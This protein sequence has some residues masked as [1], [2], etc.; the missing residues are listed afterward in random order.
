ML[1]G[2]VI[3]TRGH[4]APPSLTLNPTSGPNSV[5]GSESQPF[6]ATYT[7]VS[8]C[9]G[10]SVSYWWDAVG[11]AGMQIFGPVGLSTSS[12]PPCQVTN[13][14]NPPRGASCNV[15]HAVI[16]SEVDA[17]GAPAGQASFNYFLQCYGG[18]VTLRPTQGTP[19]Q[20]V[21]GTYNYI[22][23]YNGKPGSCPQYTNQVN[24]TWNGAAWFSST[25]DQSC[26]IA[27]NNAPPPTYNCGSN[28]Q[29]VGVFTPDNT[30]SSPASYTVNCPTPTPTSS[31]TSSSSTIT[32]S[33]ATSSSSSS[34]T[35]SSPT[36][37]TTSHHTTG[38]TSSVGGSPLAVPNLSTPGS[39][40]GASSPTLSPTPTAGGTTPS[41]TPIPG[42]GPA[43]PTTPP[44]GKDNGPTRSTF[45]RS[46]IDPRTINTDP[47]RI[48]VDLLIA[49]GLILVIVFPCELF[50]GTLEENY[51][52]VRGWFT[53]AFGA[54]RKARAH[55][56]PTPGWLIFPFFAVVM[57]GLY[58]LLD[59]NFGFD[60]TSLLLF[61][62]LLAG[63]IIVTIGFDLP[64]MLHVRFLRGER[65]E[66]TPYVGTLIVAGVCVLVSRLA[67][68][69]PGYLY[70]LVA[71]FSF[72]GRLNR[73]DEGRALAISAASVF[74]VSI[75]AYL[76]WVPVKDAAEQ[77]NPAVLALI[78]DAALATVFVAGLET[79]MFGLIPVRFLDG[80]KVIA[81]DK[82]GW[83]L[84]MGLGAFG[85]VHVVLDPKAGLVGWRDDTSALTVLA[86]FVGFG[87]V[88]VAF[89]G[90]FRLRHRGEE[91]G[92]GGSPEGPAP[93]TEP[94]LAPAPP[95]AIA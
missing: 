31:A 79:A 67:H 18:Y 61:L 85:F 16:A 23:P 19:T 77:P 46:V 54:L 62:G 39:T 44:S 35:S 6:N 2:L 74:V 53:R 43:A 93:P 7:A 42:I 51:D 91:E 50:N 33:S 87:G 60:E 86:L 38:G 20:P 10:H 65:V 83:A 66:L 30:S 95:G 14:M 26:N 13:T 55:L 29:V 63:L 11:G 48:G 88:S 84:L 92:P 24:F 4:A 36:T 90:Y 69:Q 28:N 52:E 57:A 76:L 1:A 3:P 59:P 9:D 25:L 17:T 47:G 41:A 34:T 27:L 21:Q 78:G 70:G 71:G 15:S 56:P 8:P 22:P 40:P 89:W 64:S 5:P 12:A 72:A 82:R 58:G 94:E 32:S 45:V 80:A 68:F 75:L 81:W 37:S 49:L 73:R